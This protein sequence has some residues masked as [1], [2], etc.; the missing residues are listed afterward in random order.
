MPVINTV[1]AFWWYDQ[2]AALA[3]FSVRAR[4]DFLD[5]PTSGLGPIGASEFDHL[6]DDLRTLWV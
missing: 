6:I 5:E 1:R 2:R 4:F 3:C